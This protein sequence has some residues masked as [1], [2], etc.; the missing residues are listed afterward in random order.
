MSV[1][2]GFLGV[3]PLCRSLR[4]QVRLVLRRPALC[5]DGRCLS[6]NVHQEKL[7]TYRKVEW[8]AQ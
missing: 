7:Q 3:G 2:R 1:W 4:Q 8:L 5:Q 6:P